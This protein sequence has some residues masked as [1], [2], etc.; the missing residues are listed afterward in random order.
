M[1]KRENKSMRLTR[2]K[3]VSLLTWLTKLFM[4]L[5]PHSAPPNAI[6][7][8]AIF[9]L[10][11]P[12]QIHS[13]CLFSN[14]KCIKYPNRIMQIFWNIQWFCVL[15]IDQIHLLIVKYQYVQICRNI[16]WFL[17]TLILNWSAPKWIMSILFWT[18]R[19]L[20]QQFPI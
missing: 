16:Q 15:R 2:C 11:I 10:E 6:S 4:A 18:F 17:L 13:I 9:P 7:R 3:V 20:L 12:S 5:S 19:F 1:N 14:V 8:K